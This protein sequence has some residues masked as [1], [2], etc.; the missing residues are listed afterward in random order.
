MAIRAAAVVGELLSSG[1]HPCLDK[2][3]CAVEITPT[4]RRA[5]LGRAYHPRA[6]GGR[7][8]GALFRWITCMSSLCVP[9]SPYQTV[10]LRKN[11]RFTLTF[12]GASGSAGS[13][14]ST[15]EV[16]AAGFIAAGRPDR[17]GRWR[18]LRH[19]CALERLCPVLN[20]F[21][22][23]KCLLVF[24][25]GDVRLRRGEHLAVPLEDALRVQLELVL[26]VLEAAPLRPEGRSGLTAWS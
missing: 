24:G 19:D 11:M 14:G 6:M 7:W 1:R 8:T 3:A 26:E 16:A 2:E 10:V 25:R 13:L 5:S 4:P 20:L 12:L 23:V 9:I 21:V 17:R 15:T 22:R 18:L